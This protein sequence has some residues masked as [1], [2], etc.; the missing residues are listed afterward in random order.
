MLK[1]IAILLGTLTIGM[2]QL[3]SVDLTSQSIAIQQLPAEGR[4]SSDFGFRVR[5]CRGGSHYHPG[6]DIANA[7]ATPI[8]ATGAG[9]VVSVS[10]DRGYGLMVEID[11][12]RGWT[13]RYAHLSNVDVKE[14]DPLRAGD[15]VGE[16]G[17]SGR[18]TGVHLHYE[19]RRY[20]LAV[21]PAPYL[22]A[23]QSVLAY[24]N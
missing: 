2:G 13:T 15:S 11:H 17:R 22:A 12:G 10:R 5:P 23:A 3:M 16:M 8:Q 20:G 24:N 4:F 14:G 21:N 7:H 18:A 9:V 19:L 6:V 1:L